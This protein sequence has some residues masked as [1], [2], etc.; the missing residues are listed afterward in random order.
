MN[1]TLLIRAGD[2]DWNRW[3]APA[4]HDFYHTS[5]YHSFSESQG[6]GEAWLA[7]CGNPDRYLAW[8][9]LVRPVSQMA[10]LEQSRYRDI[11][12]VYGYGGPATFGCRQDEPFIAEA[13]TDIERLWRNQGCIA[14]FSRLHP[15]LKNHE[16]LL[17]HPAQT[18]TV[19]CGDTISLDL[20]LQGEVAVR[21]Y[22][23]TTRQEI[24]AARAKGVTTV[25]DHNW[26]AFDMF[27]DL[28]YSTMLRNRASESYSF[29][30]Q[31]LLD[32][33]RALGEHALLFVT[34]FRNEVA[35]VCIMVEYRG[36]LAAHLEGTNTA[37]LQ[38]SPFKVLIDDARRIG[39]SRGNHVLHLGGGRG[40]SEDSLFAFKTKF[41]STRHSFWLYRNVLDA[42]AYA[43]LCEERSRTA[44]LTGF[45]WQP[46]L[47]FPA[48][49]TPLHVQKAAVQAAFGGR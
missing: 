35:A 41:S 13:L 46:G 48:Y 30:R 33:K 49:R 28:Y 14:A 27:C 24:R 9:Y 4:A 26:D 21:D 38:Y 45:E 23:R 43:E 11:T 12:S 42:K 15:L 20:N 31:Y 22:N 36:M 29:S 19:H 37:L 39:G 17:G 10:G 25:I 16:L 34:S 6:E 3:M 32:L 40:G 47:F 8:P 44:S 2:P 18:H 5:E 7:V 1:R